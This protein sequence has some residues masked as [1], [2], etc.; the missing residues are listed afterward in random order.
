MQSLDWANVEEGFFKMISSERCEGYASGWDSR[1]SV[2]VVGSDI[3][4]Y[5][6]DVKVADPF[7]SVRKAWNDPQVDVVRA[8]LSAGELESSE[9]QGA[10]PI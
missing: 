9:L 3:A 8:H 5:K 2:K 7:K 10:N 6:F 4:L 1:Y